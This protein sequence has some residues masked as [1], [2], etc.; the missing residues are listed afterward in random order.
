MLW[1]EWH[2]SHVCECYHLEIDHMAKTLFGRITT[3]AASLQ[4]CIPHG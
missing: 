2:V 4:Y 3:E 1:L